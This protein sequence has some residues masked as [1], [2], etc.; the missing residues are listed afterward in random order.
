MIGTIAVQVVI[1]EAATD[2]LTITKQPVQQGA[3]ITDHAFME[4]TAFAHTIYFPSPGFT[5]GT[6]LSQIYTKLLT[7][8]SSAQPFDIV[9]PKRIYSSMLMTSLNQTTDKLTENCLAIHAS[10]QQ[11]ILVPVLA[12]QVQ[13][14]NLAH[15]GSNSPT[16]NGGNKSLLLRGVNT[17]NPSVTGFSAPPQ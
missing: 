12:T 4:P 11:I 14:N 16:Q 10:Y 8:Q 1:D 17:F 2:T 7:L 13:I 6:T 5:G 15:R 3:A 9:T